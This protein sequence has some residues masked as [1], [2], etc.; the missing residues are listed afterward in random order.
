MEEAV[1]ELMISRHGLV[2]VEFQLK[3][4]EQTEVKTVKCFA[5]PEIALRMMCRP[6][7]ES[8]ANS[9]IDKLMILTPAYDYEGIW[10]FSS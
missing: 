7:E 5:S 1:R 10:F 6:G 9:N 8:A 2:M 4:D 3:N